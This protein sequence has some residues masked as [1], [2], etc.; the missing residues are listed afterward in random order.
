[1]VLL[2]RKVPDFGLN[3]LSPVAPDWQRIV[4]HWH[5]RTQDRAS[6]MVFQ[7]AE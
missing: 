3:E 2:S 6:A 4:P 7:P 1:L 5:R